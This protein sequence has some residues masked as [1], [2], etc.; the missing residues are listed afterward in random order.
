MSVSEIV[1]LGPP[2]TYAHE[3]AR[4]RYGRNGYKLIDRET[5]SE[6]CKRV[7]SSSSRKGIIPIENSSGGTIYSS[8]DALLNKKLS[9]QIEEELALNVKLALLGRSGEKIE[10]IYTH[11]APKRYCMEWLK[12]KYPQADLIE[13]SSTG[14][15]AREASRVHCAGAIGSKAAAAIYNMEVLEY[16][17]PS[18]VKINVTHFFVIT[19]RCSLLPRI[20][21]TSLG[22]HLRNKPGS[23]YDFLRPLADVKINLSRI[24]SR[25]I[26]GRP[27]EFAFFIDVDESIYKPK[28]AKALKEA[29]KHTTELRVLGSYPCFRLYK[30]R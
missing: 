2:G 14:A 6:V 5:V 25:P 9:L 22:V 3:V 4:K 13:T 30:S 11:F 27:R 12:K 15:A 18:S 26:E 17:I 20:S 21:K 1:Y 7:A 23:L 24:V 19:K 28:L 29:E 8:V 10:T 16:P